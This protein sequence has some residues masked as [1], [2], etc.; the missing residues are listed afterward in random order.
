MWKGENSSLGFASWNQTFVCLITIHF[1]QFCKSQNLSFG[2]QKRKKKRKYTKSRSALQ[3]HQNKWGCI[4]F[5]ASKAKLV[6]QASC[7]T[8][9]QTKAKQTAKQPKIAQKAA[10]VQSC[11]KSIRQHQHKT[12][13]TAAEK[14]NQA[15][16]KANYPNAAKYSSPNKSHSRTNIAKAKSN[17]NKQKL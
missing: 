13:Q 8:C 6:R 10:H 2:S 11:N 5:A 12:N 1:S 4:A 3:N 17:C 7:L 15:A 16:N 9:C 14:Q